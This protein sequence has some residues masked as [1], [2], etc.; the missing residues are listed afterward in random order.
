MVEEDVESNRTGRG[1]VGW[2]NEQWY[3]FPLPLPLQL[4]LPAAAYREFF[5]FSHT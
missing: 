2:N 3:N 4:Q 1:N 5:F